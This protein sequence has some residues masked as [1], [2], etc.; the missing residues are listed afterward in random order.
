M[1]FFLEA[2]FFLTQPATIT[3]PITLAIFAHQISNQPIPKNK[4]S[5]RSGGLIP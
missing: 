2:H 1:S 3:Y 5:S 4:K